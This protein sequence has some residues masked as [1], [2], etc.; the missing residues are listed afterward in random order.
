MISNVR[1]RTWN[2][3]RYIGMMWQRHMSI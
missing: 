1:L 2:C 3:W